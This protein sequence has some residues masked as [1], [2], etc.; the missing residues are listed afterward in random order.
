VVFDGLFPLHATGVTVTDAVREHRTWLLTITS[1]NRLVDPAPVPV[2][3]FGVAAAPVIVAIDEL[4]VHRKLAPAGWLVI[5]AAILLLSPTA[6]LKELGLR[7]TVQA[8]GG[9][10]VGVG[11]GPAVATLLQPVGKVQDEEAALT[12]QRTR[13]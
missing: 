4:I 2:I 3:V 9:V 6:I 8:D 11:H 5:E 12:L 1:T 7:V 10:G 13:K